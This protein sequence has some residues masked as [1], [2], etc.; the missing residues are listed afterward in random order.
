[1]KLY[2][3]ILLL[4]LGSSI[5]LHLRAQ[6]DYQKLA[7]IAYSKESKDNTFDAYIPKDYKQAKVIVYLHGSGWTG[8]D[9]DEFPIQLVQELVAKRKYIV[10]SAN[11]RLIKDGKNRF[12]A[13][14]ED[15]KTLL[16]FLSKQASKFNFDGSSFA[17]MGGSAGGHLA[18]LYAYGYD[19]DKHVKTVVDFWGPTDFTNL[20][21]RTTNAEANEKIVNLLG[22]PDAKAPI[23]MVASPIH[24]LTK[25]TGTPTLLFHGGKDPLVPVDQA[26]RLYKK[27]QDLGIPS[28]YN[29]YEN[30]KH[31]MKGIAALDVLN[32][33][34]N[35]LERY[36]P[37]K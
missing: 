12:P 20:A 31:G 16:A 4:F 27:L 26:N 33:T 14:M 18:L 19:S 13:Q 8:G 28:E 17:L 35:W 29:Y 23:N 22:E 2:T 5:S 37:A 24:R 30:E 36:F 25:D 15:V 9:K 34:I 10:V 1:M 21:E 3:Y 11:Y 32:K 7:D 6:S